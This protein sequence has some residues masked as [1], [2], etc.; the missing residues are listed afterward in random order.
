VGYH[1]RCGSHHW[2]NSEDR[3]MSNEQ[4]KFEL[5]YDKCLNWLA[6]ADTHQNTA[7]KDWR[8]DHA[9]R[10][11]GHAVLRHSFWPNW[12]MNLR[13]SA[14]TGAPYIDLQCGDTTQLNIELN[15]DSSMRV[16]LY[17]YI[18]NVQNRDFRRTLRKMFGLRLYSSNCLA[19]GWVYT[20]PY[21]KAAKKPISKIHL[22]KNKLMLVQEEHKFNDDWSNIIML[23]AREIWL[24]PDRTIRSGGI[25]TELT[26][27]DKEKRK[28][29][30]ANVRALRGFVGMFRSIWEPLN[31]EE[32]ATTYG[33]QRLDYYHTDANAD[34]QR[35]VLAV[36]EDENFS[37][38]AVFSKAVDCAGK[39]RE[40][41]DTHGGR[42]SGRDEVRA[43]TD[44]PEYY[45]MSRLMLR[46]SIIT[47]LIQ[48]DRTTNEPFLYLDNTVATPTEMERRDRL[49]SR[50]D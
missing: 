16:S 32:E 26:I 46:P 1:I 7:P 34:Q 33:N 28:P 11:D 49:N 30:Q 23:N 2:Y 45:L 10:S 40:A 17:D 44:V 13:A 41:I 24:N 39:A 27:P 15:M 12:A 20:T 47:K 50:G 35:K 9:F 19:P 5:D 36:L 38:Q 14:I 37:A 4:E 42:W 6:V 31:K 43:F 8:G 48:V 21:H 22:P 3:D 29:L 25:D 18:A